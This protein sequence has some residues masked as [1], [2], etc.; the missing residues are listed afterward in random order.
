MHLLKSIILYWNQTSC[1]VS[2]LSTTVLN[3]FHHSRRSGLL[4][5]VSATYIT[6]PT[7][8]IST[9][10]NW[11]LLFQ[12]AK[13]IPLIFSSVKD[14][15]NKAGQEYCSTSKSCSSLISTFDPTLKVHTLHTKYFKPPKAMSNN[16]IQ[17]FLQVC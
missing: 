15:I 7:L 14:R 5:S 12:S 8:I 10:S 11:A 1:L 9:N 17:N 13:S 6:L 16:L 2:Y 3:Q 4:I